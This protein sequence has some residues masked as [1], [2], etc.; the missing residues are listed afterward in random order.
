MWASLSSPQ[1]RAWAKVLAAGH[2]FE[3][4]SQEAGVRRWDSDGGKINTWLPQW[5]TRTQSLVTLWRTTRN[6]P[7]S[8]STKGCMAGAL[9]PWL[10]SPTGWELPQLT[11]HILLGFPEQ[12]L[13]EFLP[14]EKAPRQKTRNTRPTL[15]IQCLPC[16][17]CPPQ[18]NKSLGKRCRA[19]K[20]MDS[21]GLNCEWC[22]L[23]IQSIS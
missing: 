18:M 23:V 14:S 19:H 1:S 2:L 7:H 13:G 8:Y 21:M 5:A 10:P 17:N 9:I 12:G 4:W 20:T 16:A 22:S 3:R 15:Q 6:V 11:L